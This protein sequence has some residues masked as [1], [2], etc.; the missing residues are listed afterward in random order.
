[1][2]SRD[3]PVVVSRL[4]VPVRF[5]GRRPHRLNASHQSLVTCPILASVKVTMLTLSCCIGL[6]VAWIYDTHMQMRLP[7]TPNS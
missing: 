6:A 2:T 1:M 7:H 3:T 4:F 5:Q